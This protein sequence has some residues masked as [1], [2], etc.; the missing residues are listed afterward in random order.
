MNIDALME[1]WERDSQY[2]DDNLDKESL[3]SPK[4]HSKYLKILINYKMKLSALEMDY[5]NLRQKKF[6]YYRGE[7]PKSELQENGWDQWQGIKP[8]KSDMEEFLEGDTDLNA[9]RLKMQYIKNIIDALDSIMNQLK[10]RD[11][12]IRNAI[13]WKKFIAGS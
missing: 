8:L 1:I 10:S 2:D 3:N 5:K 13:E 4:L 9:I 12:Q 7:M 6:R 11:W